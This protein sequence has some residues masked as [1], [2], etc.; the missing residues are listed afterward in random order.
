MATAKKSAV[1]RDTSDVGEMPQLIDL[2]DV[3]PDYS[4]NARSVVEEDSTSEKGEGGRRGWI[5]ILGDIATKAVEK[6]GPAYVG[7]KDPIVVRPNPLYGKGGPSTNKRYSVVEGFGR[8]RIQLALTT[9]SLPDGTSLDEILTDPKKG[10]GLTSAQVASLRSS[11]AKIRAYVREMSEAEAVKS[12]V[13]ENLLRDDLNNTD[14]FAAIVRLGEVFPNATGR[15]IAAMTGLSQPYIDKIRKIH[16]KI[17][18]VTLPINAFYDGMPPT[19]LLTAWRHD[20]KKLNF[21]ALYELATNEDL[22]KAGGYLTATGRK[23]PGVMPTPQGSQPSV[24]PGKSWVENA[25][26]G[27]IPMVA[28]FLV[29]LERAGVIPEVAK[30]IRGEETIRAVVAFG[31]GKVGKDATPAQLDEVSGMFLGELKKQRKMASEEAQR[32]AE[33]E[34]EGDEDSD[35]TPKARASGR[36]PSNGVATA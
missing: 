28:K 34:A 9:G 3:Y 36:K 21:N 26:T 32:E 33:A 17:G 4:W 13:Q 10:I 18:N 7:Q 30:T 29:T 20:T 12:N 31:R 11:K 23:V 6:G 8:Y 35:E 16:D 24:S 2:H 15:D 19:A 1:M 22:D 27:Y 14:K 5:G 25:K